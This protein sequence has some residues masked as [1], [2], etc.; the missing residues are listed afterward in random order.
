MPSRL[1]TALVLAAAAV[2]T[3]APAASAAPVCRV[4][5]VGDGRLVSLT[6]CVTAEVTGSGL[7][8]SATVQV[9][10]ALPPIMA[11]PEACSGTGATVGRTGI[12]SGWYTRSPEFDPA[13]GSIR[14]YGTSGWV[15]VNGTPYLVTIPGFC[16]GEPAFCA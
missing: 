7:S 4:V 11:E 13:T 15:Y 12:D 5:K 1:L 2:T 10:C 16:V 6:V 14:V 3:A 8:R 9:T